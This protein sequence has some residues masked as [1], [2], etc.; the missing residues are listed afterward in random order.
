MPRKSI[1]RFAIGVT[2]AL[3]ASFAFMAPAADA[4]AVSS[5]TASP[6]SLTAG[7]AA[8]YTID[9]TTSSTGALASGV[10]TI[11]LS[12][13]VGTQFPLIANDYTVNATL[14]S[15]APSHTAANNVTITTP[16]TVPLSTAVAVVAGV[17]NTVTNTTSAGVGSINVRTSIDATVVP[18]SPAFTIVAGAASQVVAV[19]GSGQNATVGTAFTNPLTATIEDQYGNP[20]LVAS[21]VVTFTA[22]LTG[23]SGTFLSGTTDFTVTNGSGTAT[24]TAFSAG[25]ES[26]IDTVTAA[27]SGVTSGLF[28]EANVAG[29][30]SEVVI[31]TGGSQTAGIG[32][33]F[34]TTLQAT[35]GDQFGNPV[36]AAGT[37]VTFTAPA[38]GASGTF[39]NGTGTTNA[40]TIASGVATAIGHLYR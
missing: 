37:T 14:V 30:P 17:G 20:V 18:S 40:N 16:V 19:A 23:P 13:P 7:A 15:A 24:T 28:T 34:A 11:T 36:L 9:F 39:A 3:I 25:T 22:P 35:V 21:Q 1:R 27:S 10:D 6:S 2:A 38:S 31:T 29:N 5:V 8:T 4:A 12:G 26:G 32:T 33:S